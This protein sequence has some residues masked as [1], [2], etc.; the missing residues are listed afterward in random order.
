MLNLE[1]GDA[2]ALREALRLQCFQV[3]PRGLQ[4]RVVIRHVDEEE[5]HVVRAQLA[6]GL[7]ECVSDSLPGGYLVEL[8][9]D[10]KLGAWH[11]RG[12]DAFADTILV[13]VHLR[14][15]DVAEPGLDCSGDLL[16]G[17]LLVQR[18]TRAEGKPR[19]GGAIVQLD[20]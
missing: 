16:T 17:I 13:L 15:V 1:V 19:D 8:G 4:V 9:S 10:I 5:I 12:D 11:T 18:R 3:L 2:D 14:G 7:D 20:W 6:Q